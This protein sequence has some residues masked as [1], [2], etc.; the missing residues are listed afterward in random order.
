MKQVLQF[1]PRTFAH[2]DM[3]GSFFS[4]EEDGE[5]KE[6]NEDKHENIV[7]NLKK[8]VEDINRGKKKQIE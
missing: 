3:K 2:N 4:E 5:E 8:H 6:N 1:C 7:G